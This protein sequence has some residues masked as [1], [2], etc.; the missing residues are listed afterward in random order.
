MNPHARALQALTRIRYLSC[1]SCARESTTWKSPSLRS[2]ATNILSSPHQVPLLPSR[3]VHS[4][5]PLCSTDVKPSSSDPGEPSPDPAAPDSKK[6]RLPPLSDLPHI[7]WPSFFK[8]I[9]NFIL[10]TFII[11]PYLDQEFY[12]SEFMRG[13]KQVRAYGPSVISL[14]SSF[15]VFGISCF[16]RRS[17]FSC[18]VQ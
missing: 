15:N 9:R 6:D 16:N 1:N 18:D 11:R 14:C 10:S 4:S 17:D 8:T 3:F 5:R 7:L 2:S 12:A 13:A